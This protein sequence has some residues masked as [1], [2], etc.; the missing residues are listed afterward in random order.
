MSEEVEEA[1]EPTEVVDRG[2][3]ADS[4]KVVI[5]SEI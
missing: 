1:W 5:C 4:Y 2:D 3:I